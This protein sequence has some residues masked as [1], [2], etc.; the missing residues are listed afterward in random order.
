MYGYL[1]GR[2]GWMDE[3]FNPVKERLFDGFDAANK[4]AVLLVDIAGGFGHYTEGFLSKFPDAPGR[5]ILQD[6]P[7]VLG[8]IQQLHPRIEKMEYDFFT[9]QPVKGECHVR[10]S[11]NLLSALSFLSIRKGD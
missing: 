8:Q 6:L 5:L 11:F 2:S 7:P 4:D 9:E 3:G 1:L 10:H